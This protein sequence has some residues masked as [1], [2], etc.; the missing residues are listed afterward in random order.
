MYLSQ[1]DKRYILGIDKFLVDAKVDAGDGNPVFCPCKDCMNQR[2]WA[3]IES[4]Q[5]HLLTRG[6]M[7]NYT[8]WSMHGEIVVN[9]PQENNDD[10][11]M[12]DIA[13]HEAVTN[14]ETGV[15]TQNLCLPLMMCL[16]IR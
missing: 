14:E 4:I 9:V 2:K 8:M 3:R 7:P 11:V 5:M 15:S 13:L 16:D 1:T 6:F 10:M 12:P